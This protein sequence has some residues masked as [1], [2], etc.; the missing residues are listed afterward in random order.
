MDMPSM[1]MPMATSGTHGMMAA[2]DIDFWFD[3]FM[4]RC[5]QP[6]VV[7]SQI[8]VLHTCYPYLL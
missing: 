3:K 2:A 8:S 7:V 1:A 6:S 5:F 4:I